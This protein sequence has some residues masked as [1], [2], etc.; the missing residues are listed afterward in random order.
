MTDEV[1]VKDLL[2]RAII[3][4][5]DDERVNPQDVLINIVLFVDTRPAA[6][7]ENIEDAANYRTLT[8]EIMSMVEASHFFLVEKL[9]AEI[10]R[11]CLADQRV[12]RA[13]VTVEKPTA[14]RFARSVG[15][16]IERAQG[17]ELD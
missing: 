14:L 8:K 12:E 6:R 5:N 13:R 3:G 17:D 1:F 11:L 9:T 4:I 15:I 16:T 10:M 2:V 7:S